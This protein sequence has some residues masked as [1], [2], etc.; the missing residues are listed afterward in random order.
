[1]YIPTYKEIMLPFLEY[2]GDSREYHRTEIAEALGELVFELT[3]EQLEERTESGHYKFRHRCDWTRYFLKD[4]GLIEGPK[5][6][7]SKITDRGL[8]L[9]EALNHERQEIEGALLKSPAKFLEYINDRLP[10]ESEDDDD[11]TSK[12]LF[13]Y[14]DDTSHT[15]KVSIEDIPNL[16]S[17]ILPFLQYIGD[18][19]EYRRM[20]ITNALGNEDFELTPAHWAVVRASGQSVFGHRCDWVRF[21]LKEANL[22]ESP[23]TGYSRITSR[24]LAL[25]EAWK[26]DPE[27]IESAVLKSPAKFLDYVENRWPVKG[28]DDSNHTPEELFGYEDGDAQIPEESLEENNQESRKVLPNGTSRDSIEE[29]YQNIK[30]EL[31]RVMLQQIKDNTPAFFENLVI[32]LLV[33]MGYGG[34]REDVEKA[35]N[36]GMDG[37]IDGIIFEDRLGLD[38]IYLQA[39]WSEGNVDEPE[40]VGFVG[41]LAGRGTSKGIYITTSNFTESA[42]AYD[43]SGF[44][45]VLID[46]NQ[47]ALL[48]IEHNVGVSIEKTYEI[49][50]VDSDYFSENTELI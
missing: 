33:K 16:K 23:R 22:I 42:K 8:M 41:V 29:N 30:K 27:E 32:D 46:G 9:L 13:D 35:V 48:M 25:L 6:G 7:Y 39:K 19:R 10:V 2:I 17:I 50:R 40:I 26:N 11:Q 36:R 31:A 38:V 47:L 3:P 24:G 20:E 28:W 15:P 21:H 44:K 1:M 14:E 4:A 43:A 12:E 18:S 37:N 34:S 49:K 5:S 45:I